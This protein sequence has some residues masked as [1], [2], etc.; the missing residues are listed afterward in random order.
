MDSAEDQIRVTLG[1]Y[2]HVHDQMD[3]DAFLEL[4]TEDGKMSVISGA[5]PAGKAALR[6]FIGGTYAK[7]QSAGRHMKHLYANS[8]IA[9]DG[10]RATVSTDV[11]AYESVNHGPWNINM[12]GEVH[13]VLV[14]E[15]GRWLFQERNVVDGRAA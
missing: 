6:E 4:F 2:A 5:R 11:V 15:G 3:L 7:R 8:I 10:A 1:Q 12:V 9:V 14:L 13:D